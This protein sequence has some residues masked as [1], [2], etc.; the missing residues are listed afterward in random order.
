MPKLKIFEEK[1]PSIS[2]FVDE[3]GWIEIGI[4]EQINSFVRAYDY[5]GTVY[6]GKSSYKDIE[7]AFQDLEA[8]IKAHLED[9][10]L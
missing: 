10:G 6:Q 9:R 3:F 1:Y 4:S 5:G 2:R 8:K 7:G